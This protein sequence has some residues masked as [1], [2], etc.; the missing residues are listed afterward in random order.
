ML[1]GDDIHF[2]HAQQHL[3]SST[4]STAWHMCTGVMDIKPSVTAI[5]L[6]AECQKLHHVVHVVS[7]TGT[8]K[9]CRGGV[10]IEAILKHFKKNI[11]HFFKINIH[12]HI[13]PRVQNN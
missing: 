2:F 7:K 9:Q 3:S 11:N 8:I 6:P 10:S 13:V 1:I 4:K 5:P 12:G